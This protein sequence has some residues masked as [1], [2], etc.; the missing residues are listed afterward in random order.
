MVRYARFAEF[1]KHKDIRAERY[2]KYL[3]NV[4]GDYMTPPPV[5]KQKSHHD[6]IELDLNKS[7]ME[8]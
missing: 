3:T 1:R 2:D 5:E 8:K 6:Y 7:Y 4:Y